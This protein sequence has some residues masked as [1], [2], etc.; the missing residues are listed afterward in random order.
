LVSSFHDI[1][2]FEDRLNL[3]S[4]L[5]E[6]EIISGSTEDSFIEC[7]NCP[8]ATYRGVLQL[9]TDPRKLREMKC[10]ICNSPLTFYVPYE[11]D[12]SI[13]EIVKSKDGLIL[14]ALLVKLRNGNLGFSINQV[15][16]NDIEI[17]CIYKIEGMLCIV[18][19]KMYKQNTTS[20]LESKLKEHLT[21]L[22][23]DILRIIESGKFKN[24]KVKPILLVNIS[25]NNLLNQVMNEVKNNNS[26]ELFQ[27]A[28]IL[29]IEQI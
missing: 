12:K 6:S 7:T 14:D 4:I 9:K 1:D 20:K 8:P 28:K 23:N 25:D 22:V 18:E 15:F 3:F 17:D 5:Y 13:Y 24:E 11:L 27:G 2:N 19:C 26:H 21:K 29:T 10:P 16:L